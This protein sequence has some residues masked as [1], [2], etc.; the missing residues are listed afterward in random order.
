MCIYMF[1]DKDIRRVEAHLK[2]I[3]QLNEGGW[4][5][6]VPDIDRLSLVEL[7]QLRTPKLELKLVLT[8]MYMILGVDES[9]LKVRLASSI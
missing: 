9:F 1:I 2:F 5:A 6:E 3:M 7:S 8:A 4:I